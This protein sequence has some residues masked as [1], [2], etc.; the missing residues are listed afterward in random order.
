[1]QEIL[2]DYE[3]LRQIGIT[4]SREQLRRLELTGKF[5]LRYQLGA[6]RRA[7]RL[8]EI[9]AWIASRPTGPSPRDGDS[10]A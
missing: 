1:M 4:F 2:T 5:P 10:D 8:S 6:K 3:G 7:W 9:E